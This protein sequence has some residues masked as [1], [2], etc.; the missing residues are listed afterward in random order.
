[1]P[2]ASAGTWPVGTNDAAAAKAALVF[3]LQKSGLVVL[4]FAPVDVVP[5]MMDHF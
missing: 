1:M 2:A 4:A 5:D 3:V